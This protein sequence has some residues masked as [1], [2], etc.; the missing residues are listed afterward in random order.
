MKK[1]R[2]GKNKLLL[3]TI[4]LIF[5]ILMMPI[6]QLLIRSK[7]ITS[8]WAL[9]GY[10]IIYY[11]VFK[12]LLKLLQTILIKVNIFKYSSDNFSYY[13]DS[14]ERSFNETSNINF[15]KNMDIYYSGICFIIS[16][17]I[18]FGTMLSLTTDE[19]FFTIIILSVLSAIPLFLLTPMPKET[20][21]KQAFDT[22]P[23]PKPKKEKF[24]SG[25]KKVYIRGKNGEYAGEATTYNFGN[26][27]YTDIRDKNGIQTGEI[28]SYEHKTEYKSK[29]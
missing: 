1:K 10:M 26:Y 12:I 9:L 5:G 28:N 25:I 18:T 15:K 21:Y 20:R 23:Q 3:C 16:S 17:I 22:T 27:Q 24:N 2:L 13:K 29:R 8:I 4:G 14:L 11:I 6:Y 19:S 7:E